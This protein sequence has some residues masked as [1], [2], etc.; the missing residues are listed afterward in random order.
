LCTFTAVLYHKKSVLI[1]SIFNWSGGKDSSLCLHHVLEG[2]KYNV[3]KLLT[4]L[5][6]ASRRVSMHGVRQELLQEQAR[7]IGLPLQQV[8]LPGNASMQGYNELMEQHMRSQQQQG[9]THAIFGDINLADLRAYRE[10]QLARI[11]LQAVFPLWNRP[12]HELVQEFL[13][14]NFKAVVVC[15]NERVLDASFAGRIFD[16]SFLQDLPPHVDPAGE[17]GEFHTFV[18]D[19]PIFREPV[20]YILGEKVRRTYPPAASQNNNCGQQQDTP[21]YDNAFWFRDL[22]P[23]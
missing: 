7:Q 5:S 19:G 6:G 20:Q 17:N 8:F 2:K 3:R 11:P 15:V 12:T 4:T 22:L 10:E 16:E 18:F 21:V 1:P 13:Q 14:L 9:V 23:I